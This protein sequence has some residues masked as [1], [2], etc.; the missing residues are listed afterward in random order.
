M[1]SFIALGVTGILEAYQNCIRQVQ[2]WGPTNIAPIIH[3]VA[4]FA[5]TAQAEEST[6]GAAV[7][8]II[9]NFFFMNKKIKLVSMTVI[10]LFIGQEQRSEKEENKK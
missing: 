8:E 7:S 3:H 6:K 4:R 9:H 1:D 5:Q 10:S 2:L